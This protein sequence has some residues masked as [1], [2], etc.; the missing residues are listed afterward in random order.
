MAWGI[1]YH[2][3]MKTHILVS[4][5]CL[6]ASLS[7][8]SEV[9]LHTHYV[10]RVEI[11]T[12]GGPLPF[13]MKTELRY[14]KSVSRMSGRPILV[15]VNGEERIDAEPSK[16]E[17]SSYYEEQGYE[18]H[19]IRRTHT[20]R[21]ISFPQ[22]DSELSWDQWTGFGLE[23]QAT[24]AG[25]WKKRRGE[26][27]V[28]LPLLVTQ[29]D[30]ST[31]PADEQRFDKLPLMIPSS[32]GHPDGYTNEMLEQY[33][34][35]GRWSVDFESSDEL[36]VGV[37]AVDENQLATGTFLTTTGDYRFLSGRVD[38]GLMRLST[39]DGA[40]A[41]LFHARLQDDG[42]IVGDFWSGN[43]HHETWTAVCDDDA[44]LPD[45]FEQT[46]VT[47]PEAIEELV[48]KDLDG[49]PTRVLD[50]L[51]RSG[52]KARIIEIFGS[53]CPNCSDAGRE[54]V[55]LKESFG[56]DLAIVGLAFEITEDFGRS[57]E[58]VKRHHEH[59]GSDWPIL[60]GGLYDKDKATETLGF[61]DRVRSYP[62]LVFLDEQ[63]QVQAV[64]SGFSG[65]A[66]G[67]A[68]TKQRV[69][70]EELI[71]SAIESDL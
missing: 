59:I 7:L 64:H 70:F 30:W 34:F 44:Q 53:W 66:T 25:F 62:T 18:S 26:A 58:Q 37:F 38:R 41:F 31:V 17:T 6:F 15:L 11:M 40:H 1:E 28:E 23:P 16:S 46:T 51:D 47:D 22:Y 56:D 20:Q 49:T 57:V 14:D 52:A 63:N 24:W 4:L 19:F 65:P 43:W 50:V 5:V 39:F 29:L 12:P 61:L 69:R 48:F 3:D 32:D 33:S 35:E 67:E 60:I 68:Y 71:R 13:V 21:T 27:W 10:Y 2:W 36:A 45:A 54:L 55:S 8:G 42:S 9:D